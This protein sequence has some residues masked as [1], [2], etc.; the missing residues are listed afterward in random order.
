[1]APEWARVPL[2]VLATAAA[3]I[4]SQALI[5]AAFSVT[6]QA[7]QLGILPRMRIRTPRCATPGRS[8]CRP[9]TGRCTLSSSLAV[10]AVRTRPAAGLG[11]R[12]RGD[13]W[14]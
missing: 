2:I 6:K 4:A 9:S 11:L 3:V 13:A 7:M 5:T 10:V 8:T 14:T 12:H 1:M